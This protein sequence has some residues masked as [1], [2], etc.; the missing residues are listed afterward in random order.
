LEDRQYLDQVIPFLAVHI[1]F[2]EVFNPLK[3]DVAKERGDAEEEENCLDEL[4][5]I[6]YKV[7]V[8][9]ISLFATLSSLMG[10]FH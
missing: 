2:F 6:K 8:F 7:E 5:P 4:M 3:V 10:T 1:E 9:L